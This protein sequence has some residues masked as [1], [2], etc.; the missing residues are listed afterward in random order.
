V[1]FVMQDQV[2]GSKA[3]LGKVVPNGKSN[4]ENLA[5]AAT[6]KAVTAK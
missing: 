1:D 3:A 5:E 6:E 4:A 2:S